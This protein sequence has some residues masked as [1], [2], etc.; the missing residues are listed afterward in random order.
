MM[1]DLEAKYGLPSNVEFCSRCVISNQRPNSSV[2]FSHSKQSKKET[3]AFNEDG[4]CQACL[5]A[6]MKD[7]INW[8]AREEELLALLGQRGCHQTSKPHCV[9]PPFFSSLPLHSFWSPPSA[10]CHAESRA[11]RVKSARGIT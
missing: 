6:D 2:E 8:K 4:V 7:E 5:T 3:I 10:H 11:I 1:S 9:V